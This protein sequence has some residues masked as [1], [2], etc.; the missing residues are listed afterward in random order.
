MSLLEQDLKAVVNHKWLDD[1]GEDVSPATVS[2]ARQILTPLCQSV[3]PDHPDITLHRDGIISVTWSNHVV[4]C[5]LGPSEL[6][7]LY[8]YNY[9][10]ESS[11][12]LLASN[13]RP[14]CII[15]NI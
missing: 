10:P 2:M 5:F 4:T 6:V 15:M 12:Y 7:V 1:E 13:A 3:A 14:D 8:G 9:P 11:H